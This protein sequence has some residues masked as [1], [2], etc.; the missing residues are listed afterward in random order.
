MGPLG[1]ALCDTSGRALGTG[2]EGGRFGDG[3]LVSWE[4]S[5]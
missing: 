3:G 1:V 2:G 4:L 5:G